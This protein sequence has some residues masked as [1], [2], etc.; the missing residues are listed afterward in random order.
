MR[1][2]K[3]ILGACLLLGCGDDTQTGGSGGSGGATG[4]SGGA[5]GETVDGGGGAGGDAINGGLGSDTASYF[6]ALTG[7]Y[8]A[9]GDFGNA[10]GDAAGDTL[11][12]V[13]NIEGTFYN[14]ILSMDGAANVLDGAGG[15][16]C[17]LGGGGD[18]S[19]TGGEGADVCLGGPGNNIFISC[20]V[21]GQ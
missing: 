12:G 17:I 2:A 18:D 4:G 15:N 10:T 14:D 5:G 21:E 20:E 13:E 3:G 7:V 8:M 16:D 9:I 19:L 11:S 1:L 6:D